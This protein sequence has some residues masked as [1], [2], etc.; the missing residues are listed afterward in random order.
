MKKA[1]LCLCIICTALLTSCIHSEIDNS[2]LVGKWVSING[3]K[4]A[5]LN[6]YIDELEIEVKNGSWDYRP[7]IS[8]EIWEYYIDKDSVLNISRIEY[9]GNDYETERYELELSFSD[10]YNTLTLWYK[11]AFSS[12]RKYTFIRR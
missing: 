12:L 7:F 3:A 5:A 8:D 10:S 4:D 2:M 11:P 1:V 6:L 9:D